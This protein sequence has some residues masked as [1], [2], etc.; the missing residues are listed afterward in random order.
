M[1]RNCACCREAIQDEESDKQAEFDSA[2]TKT[3]CACCERREAERTS[4]P[5]IPWDIDFD[6]PAGPRDKQ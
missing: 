4:G 2:D 6:C 3:L 1:Y 5:T